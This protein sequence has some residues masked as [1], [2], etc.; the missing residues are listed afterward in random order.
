[1]P[2]PKRKEGLVHKAADAHLK[3]LQAVMTMG[4][5]LAKASINRRA[6]GDALASGDKPAAE[7]ATA[8]AGATLKSYLE[9]T[10]EPVLLAIL[11]DGGTAGLE[12][13]KAQLSQRP[14]QSI[15]HTLSDET[16]RFLDAMPLPLPPAVGAKLLRLALENISRKGLSNE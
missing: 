6:L 1:M 14:D 16:S 7:R 5:D 13:L 2:K 15:P 8:H 4:F 10:L 12:I 3:K 11:A 9:Q